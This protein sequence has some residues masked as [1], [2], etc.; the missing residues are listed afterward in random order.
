MEIAA[1]ELNI[2]S[3]ALKRMMDMLSSLFSIRVS[4]IYEIS[5]EDAPGK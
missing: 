4:F 3:E 5:Q 1:G 2:E